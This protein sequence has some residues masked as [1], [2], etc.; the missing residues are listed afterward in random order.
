MTAHPIEVESYRIMAER[1]DLS[2]WPLPARAVVARM[3]HASADLDFATSARLT[4]GAVGAGVAAVRAGAPVVCDGH[5]VRVGVTGVDA[6]CL[7]DE[8]PTAPPGSTRAA[9][10][11][12]L[13][14][15]RHPDGAIFVVGNAP[16]A[17]VALLAMQVRPAL[18]VGLPVGFVGAAE[19]KAALLASGLPCITNVGEKGGSAVAA[20]AVNAIVRLAKEPS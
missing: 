16:T 4:D 2:S 19:S 3:I 7:L 6:V 1:V 14:A 5:M 13:A 9:A 15:G 17:L 8:V 20:A 11:F 12:E 18:V 10:A